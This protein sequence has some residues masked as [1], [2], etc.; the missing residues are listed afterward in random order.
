MSVQPIITGS[1]FMIHCVFRFE[2]RLYFATAGPPHVLAQ[3][4]LD[5]MWRT[6]ANP[7]RKSSLQRC[8]RFVVAPTE[9]EEQG[10]SMLSSHA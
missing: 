7:A 2:A 6:L 10:E 5:A 9:P 3:P 8:W 1:R 4:D